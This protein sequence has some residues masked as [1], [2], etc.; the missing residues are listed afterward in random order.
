M[1]ISDLKVLLQSM[2][3]EL[4]AVSYGYACVDPSRPLPLGLV[5]F[6][7]VAEAEGLTLVAPEAELA[8]AGLAFQGGW[9]RISL[10]VVSDLAAVGLTAAIAGAL[11]EVG[12]SANV[13]AGYHHD[14]F[15]VQAARAGE[16][17]VA[18]RRLSA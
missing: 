1:A 17:M 2:E 10:T 16:A 8:A 12:I 14:H 18:L 15:F 6:A 13:I 4:H 5:P 11:A 7:M 9:A 3:P